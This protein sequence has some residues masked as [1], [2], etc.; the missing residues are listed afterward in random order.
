[1]KYWQEDNWTQ[2]ENETGEVV[3]ANLWTC[4]K[5]GRQYITF[6]PTNV[7]TQNW[8]SPNGEYPKGFRET[9]ISKPLATFKVIL[10]ETTQ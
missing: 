3:D 6:Y 10:E 5:S 4:D 9:D 1:M 2:F 7:I 8:N